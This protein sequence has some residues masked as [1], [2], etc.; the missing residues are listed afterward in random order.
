MEHF[1][2]GRFN[3]GQAAE[4]NHEGYNEIKQEHLT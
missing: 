2:D 1:D 3:Y 4:R